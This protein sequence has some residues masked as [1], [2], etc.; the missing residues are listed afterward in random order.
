ML[1]YNNEMGLCFERM[2]VGKR[3][4]LGMVSRISDR[5]A[6]RHGVLILGVTVMT[7]R[8]R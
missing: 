2:P 8:E 3:S 5:R 1:C 7:E 6:E 4:Q